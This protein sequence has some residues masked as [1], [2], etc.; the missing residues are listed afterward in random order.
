MTDLR[1]RP[2]G[3][4][5]F[6]D[7]A[8]TPRETIEQA[9]AA[10]VR[11]VDLRFVDLLGAW[12]H[13]S[14]PLQEL[15]EGV[16]T[17]GIGFDGSSVRGFQ[18]IHD[19]DLL[20]LPDPASAVVDPMLKVPT[21]SL[22]CSVVDPL[23]R[24]PYSRDPRTVARK[25][26][27]H[28]RASG[29][30]TVSSFGPEAQ[31]YVFNAIRCDQN[32]H[33]GYYFL[34]SDEGIWNSGQPNNGRANLGYRPRHREGYSPVPPTDKLQD[35]RSEIALRLIAAGIDV[36]AHHHEVGTGGQCAIDLRPQSLT[37]MAD[38]VMIYKYIVKN[39]CY[40]HGLTATFMPKPLFG[41][42]GSGMHVHQSLWLDDRNL[43][44][45]PDGYAGL[46]DTARWYIGGLLA[47]TPALLA[48]AAPTT[49][50]YRRL[51]PGCGAPVHL[52]YSRRNRSACVRVPMD[53]GSPRGKRIEFRAPDPSGNP[54]LTF[55]ALL[56]AGLDGIR[57]RLEPPVPIDEDLY[58]LAPAAAARIAST[59]RSLAAALD[60]LE[61]DHAFLLVDGVF[62]PDLIATW[63]DLK[64]TREVEPL[65]LRP[66][67][68][69]FFL[70]HDV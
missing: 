52:I 69:E 60:A 3:F 15:R 57:R 53:S 35:L 37:A 18:A 46:S 13:C 29:I 36:E 27:A 40:E 56:L 22:I 34:D 42:N 58:A 48:F 8:P 4:T 45:D 11:M 33:E 5:D 19:A 16:F 44:H 49:N 67:P 50:S 47:H 14:L 21:L 1:I 9:R 59:P 26:E 30:T 51:A 65:A 28:L 55:A 41:D 24:R 70:Y 61:A 43:F 7:L 66:H 31:F 2:D 38:Q 10:G 25:A 6:D 32:S 63:L 12:Q 64:R 62:T 39:V 68:Y 23:D 20:L 54:Y 17:G